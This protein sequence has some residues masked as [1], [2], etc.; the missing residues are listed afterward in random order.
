MR[1]LYET[2]QDLESENNLKE[3][4]ERLWGCSFHKLPIRYHLDF[5]ITK[6][7]KV[8]AFAEAK[9]RNY[10]MDS[11]N[12][13]GG[14]LLSIGKWASAKQLCEA[15]GLPFILIVRTSCGVWSATIKDFIP[16]AVLLRGRKDRG[17]W[18]DVEP[19]VCLNTN[20]FR[21]INVN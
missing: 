2:S 4:L 13:M 21:K 6:D 17:D 9:T 16:D 11:I 7:D 8:V 18:Q 5:A 20:I 3:A 19:C 1:P 15:S 10:T 14:Y 12:N